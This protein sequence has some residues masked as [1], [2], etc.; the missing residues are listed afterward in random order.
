MMKAP[1]R[2]VLCLAILIF[3]PLTA[4][5]RM[6]ET[7]AQ[8]QA[9]Y[10]APTPEL[11]LPGEKP[12]MEG[13]QDVIY[14]YQGWRIRL[15]FLGGVA[16][17]MEYV[18]LPEGGA[19]KPITDAEAGAILDA[20]KGTW[21]WRERKAVSSGDFGKDIGTA[22]KGAMTGKVWE[23]GD[24]ATATLKPANITLVLELPAAAA[25]EKDLQKTRKPAVPKF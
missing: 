17:R 21:R 11:V 2:T 1:T 23:R 16:V 8:N 18:H 9:R 14:Q 5:A 22:I 15:A 12:L 10:G 4:R 24:H 3:D 25:R 19:L 7:E 20:E 13:G 6:G